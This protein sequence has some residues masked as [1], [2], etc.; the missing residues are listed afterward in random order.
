[1]NEYGLSAN[2]IDMIIHVFESYQ[3]VDKVLIFGSRAKNNYRP[4]SD[5]DLALFGDNLTSLDLQNI[6]NDID[7][8]P[9]INIVDLCIYNSITNPELK[10]EIQ[11]YGIVFYNSLA[12]HS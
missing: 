2:V 4:G 3:N 8:L 5:I 7:E 1:M 6:R 9:I 10:V 12:I 11:K